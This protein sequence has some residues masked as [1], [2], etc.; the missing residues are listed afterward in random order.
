MNV[1]VTWSVGPTT[2]I[3]CVQILQH[4][5][6]THFDNFSAGFADDD[7]GSVLISSQLSY[8]RGVRV[9]IRIYDIST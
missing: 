2:S 7:V 3:D 4:A 9:V 1:K 5:V 8:E 6:L